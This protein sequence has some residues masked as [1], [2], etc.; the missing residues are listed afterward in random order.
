MNNENSEVILDQLDEGD[1]KAVVKTD[2]V[3][4]TISNPNIL[5]LPVRI[6]VSVGRAQMTVQ[7][8]MNLTPAS[9]VSLDT[10]MQDPAD[11]YVGDRLIARGELVELEDSGGGLGIRFTE[12]CESTGQ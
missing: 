5:A 9:I 4:A 8:I 3:D 6:L 1:P 11:I 10:K 12:V 2:N 7:E